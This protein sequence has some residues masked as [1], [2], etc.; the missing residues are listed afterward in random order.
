MGTSENKISQAPEALSRPSLLSTGAP[1]ADHNILDAMPGPSE[2]AEAVSRPRRSWWWLL[3]PM[4]AATAWGI[5]SQLGQAPAVR[6]PTIAAALPQA[7]PAAHS[8]A[9]PVASI[10][11][12]PV[13]P[14]TPQA[15][16]TAST[17]VASASADP[18]RSL[19]AAPADATVHNQKT[20]PVTGLQA[21]MNGSTSIP[22]PPPP[23]PKPRSEQVSKAATAEKKSAP[24]KTKALPQATPPSP[25]NATTTAARKPPAPQPKT[26][27]QAR[28]TA[29][30]PTPP[31]VT[32]TAKTVS[33]DPD[34]ELLNAI[35][36]HLGES[37][38]A[39]KASAPSRSPQ[40][41]AELVKSCRTKDPIEAL[42]CQR[43]IC[44][45]SWGKAQACPKEQ[46]PKVA[47]TTSPA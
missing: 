40:T 16:A 12:A 25:S 31:A 26:N 9:P 36:K 33:R 43:R 32:A 21:G 46:A 17:P 37:K 2:R 45:G 11:T 28:A 23:V 10:A 1:S 4:L 7:S 8:A 3:L 30:K 42:M 15:A 41:I 39:A 19:A 5:S 34:V 24:P 6:Q 18:F 29:P 44:E 13:A 35:M 27:T 22:T 20:H 14:R 38:P 47:K